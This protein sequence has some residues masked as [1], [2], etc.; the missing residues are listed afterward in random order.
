[1]IC[2]CLYSSATLI[3][4]LVAGFFIVRTAAQKVHAC[5][6]PFER[7]KENSR[8]RYFFISA[9]DIRSY[10]GIRESEDTEGMSLVEIFASAA[11]SVS[12]LP[13]IVFF[14][15]RRSNCER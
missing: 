14:P 9:S 6:H 15:T 8:S 7:K 4:F 5:K 13:L 11:I 2:V 3:T 10:A 12:S 1:M